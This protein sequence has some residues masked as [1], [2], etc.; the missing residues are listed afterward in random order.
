MSPLPNFLVIGAPKAG[1]SALYETLRRHP[2]VFV[3]PIKEP[4]F[5]AFEGRVPTFGGPKHND[6][7]KLPTIISLAS[8]LA[9]FQDAQ[10]AKAIGEASTIYSY[11]PNEKPAE[12]IHHYIPDVRLIAILRQP[13]ERA[14][15][16]FL[17]AVRNRW[18]PL[19]DFTQAL[20]DEPRRIHEHWSYFLRYYQNGCYYARL[21]PYF[22]RFELPQIRIYLYEAWNNNPRE[23]LRDIFRFLEIDDIFVPD[24]INRHNVSI[25]PR[26]HA[27]QAFLKNP[28]P[29][30][31]IL[32][33]LLPQT[34]RRK[35]I[36]K[37]QSLNHAK[38][39]PLDPDLRR[40]LTEEYRDDILKLQ[41]LIGR[42]LSHWLK[43]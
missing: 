42:D 10:D 40:Q 29:L 23:V 39:S 13:A 37:M 26:S 27:V 17:H 5:F 8:Y 21:K 41:D 15:S 6:Y 25:L 7:V 38:P 22:E 11:Y 31:T 30:K 28:H 19:T 33:P 43:T 34:L 1:T 24:M 35:I 9:L 4:R 32:K 12:R 18:E 2:Q 16:N 3:C 14:Y 36:S 20:A